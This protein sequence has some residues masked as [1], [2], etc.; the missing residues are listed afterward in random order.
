METQTFTFNNAE[1]TEEG[2][3]VELDAAIRAAVPGENRAGYSADFGPFLNKHL[4]GKTL[5][6]PG[7]ALKITLAVHEATKKYGWESLAD[8]YVD[9][10]AQP[11]IK[12]LT[13]EGELREK[14]LKSIDQSV[15]VR[16]G[17]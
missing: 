10:I 17:L 5:T 4:N 15:A 1:L 9:V 13:P 12:Q 8:S 16:L 3:P 6:G 11:L 14:A 2:V 7:I